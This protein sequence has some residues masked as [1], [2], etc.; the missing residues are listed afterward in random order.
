M[1]RLVGRPD[2]PARATAVRAGGAV[3]APDRPRR[4]PLQRTVHPWAWWGWALC[5]GAVVSLGTNP[6]LVLGS[7][8]AIIFVVVSRRTRAPWAKAVKTYL[9]LAAFVIGFRMVM[10]IL[11]GRGRG[12]HLLFTLPSV[13]LPVWL[14][15]LHI[16]GP[17]TL[18]DLLYTGYDSLRL[19]GLLIAVGAANALANP[20]RAL[21][22][23]PPALHE[24][25]TAM[26]IALAVAPQLIESGQRVRVA[27]R[28]RGN[29]A[30]GVRSLVRIL[31]PVLEDAIER[32]MTL[33]ASMESRGYGR[34]LSDRPLGRAT[35]ALLLGGMMSLVLGSFLLLGVP[36]AL[37]WALTLLF[38]G[39]AAIVV[40][41]RTS[42]R[43]L[44]V[45]HYRPDPWQWPEDLTV[46]CGLAALAL[47]LALKATAGAS[48]LPATSPPQWP[49]AHPLMPVIALLLAF[50]GIAT[51]APAPEDL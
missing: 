33:A 19:G 6:V 29:S 2:V 31:V 51:P 9:L 47:G 5:S 34:T 17:V 12:T 42:G 15:G 38:A 40:G 18:D 1:T 16:G 35:S 10:Q 23:V 45:S 25:S 20:R 28:L 22:N 41:L 43:R 4:A 50:P 37:W 14:A 39:L 3:K 26:V 49:V 8:V 30:R 48:L 32:S 7:V 44:A 13:T 24:I 11:L 27:R 36:G 46:G 21:K